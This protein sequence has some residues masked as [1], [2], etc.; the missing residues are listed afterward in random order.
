L[1]DFRHSTFVQWVRR[2]RKKGGR[3]KVGTRTKA[4]KVVG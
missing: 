1:K 2:K 4:K 3:K